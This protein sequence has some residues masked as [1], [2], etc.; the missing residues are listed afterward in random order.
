MSSSSSSAYCCKH[1][2]QKW[3]HTNIAFG[4]TPVASV[5]VELSLITYCVTRRAI[6]VTVSYTHLRAHETE[7]DL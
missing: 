2:V 4:L 5:I 1:Q 6:A 3:R 7:A